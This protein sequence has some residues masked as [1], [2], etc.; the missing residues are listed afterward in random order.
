MDALHIIA[1]VS[2]VQFVAGAIFTVKDL[3]YEFTEYRKEIRDLKNGAHTYPAERRVAPAVSRK[4]QL[5]R[6]HSIG[7]PRT[8]GS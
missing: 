8:S 4:G 2:F 6:K 5:A 7:H 1:Y 3:I